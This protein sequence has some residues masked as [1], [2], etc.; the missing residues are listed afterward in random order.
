M[1]KLL[2]EQQP[3]CI[4]HTSHTSVSRAAR[5]NRGTNFAFLFLHT[6]FYH[7]F[8][9]VTVKLQV[10]GQNI[11]LPAHKVTKG[12]MFTLL[13]KVYRSFLNISISI[14]NIPLGYVKH[15]NSSEVQQG[16]SRQ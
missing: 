11:L 1:T 5:K 15:Q 3:M 12:N 9:E 4:L 7:P 2:T 16:E 8:R 14:E 10:R 6:K 13:K